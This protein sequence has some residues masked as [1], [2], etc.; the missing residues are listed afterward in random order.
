MN[1]EETARQ[2]EQQRKEQDAI[3]HEFSV[4][5]GLSETAMWILYL[6]T[7][8][9]DV[10]TQQEICNLCAMPKQTIHSAVSVLVNK[11]L[12]ELTP[13]AGKN[14]KRIS[15]T[16]KGAALAART[17][18]RLRKAEMQAYGRLTEEEL[19]A[20]LNTLCRL[21]VFLREETEKII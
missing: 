6:I 11:G 3:F 20:Y 7:N 13:V 12:V 2:I 9:E 4:R 19:K 10:H 5:I 17:T 16:E 15:L 18:D 8:Y 21:T 1:I 14:C